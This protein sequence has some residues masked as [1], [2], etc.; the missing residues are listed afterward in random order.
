MLLPKARLKRL[1]LVRLT[2]TFGRW[3][4]EQEYFTQD[5]RGVCDW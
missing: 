1:F 4:M 3:S 2:L 5:G